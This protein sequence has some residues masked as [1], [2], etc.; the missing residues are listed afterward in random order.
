M[1]V[2]LAFQVAYATSHQ[3]TSLHADAFSSRNS[4]SNARSSRPFASDPFGLC[5][6][7]D[8]YTPSHRLA[9]YVVL[10]I[11]IVLDRSFGVVRPKL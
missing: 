2:A 5:I 9:S 1:C 11:K 3:S 10:F 4:N 7:I 8:I 6:D